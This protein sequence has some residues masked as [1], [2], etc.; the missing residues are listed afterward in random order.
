MKYNQ[1][2]VIELNNGD[3]ATI[4]AIND[5]LYKVD[6]VDENGARKEVKNV[7]QDEIKRLIFKK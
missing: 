6:I 5:N 2:D 3:K 1:F 4:I 7:K